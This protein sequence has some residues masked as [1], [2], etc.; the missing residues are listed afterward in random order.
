M[1]IVKKIPFGSKGLNAFTSTSKDRAVAILFANTEETND[2]YR[3]VLLQF[4]FDTSNSSNDLPPCVD[5]SQI[6]IIPGEGEFLFLP[7]TIVQI[8]DYSIDDEYPQIHIFRLKIV[9]KK[10]YEDPFLDK[11][12]NDLLNNMHQSDSEVSFILSLFP[13]LGVLGKR[14]QIIQLI[15]NIPQTSNPLF[16]SLRLVANFCNNSVHSFEPSEMDSHHL[17]PPVFSKIR[18]TIFFATALVI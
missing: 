3:S 13:I 17:G 10:A 12:R 8:Q 2:K 5:I 16:E 15:N 4:D 7:G 6:S 1:L 9:E 11:L 14:D 18:S